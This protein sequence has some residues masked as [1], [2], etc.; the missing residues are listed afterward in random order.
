MGE[1]GDVLFIDI[2]PLS[3]GIETAGGIMTKLIE[4]IAYARSLIILEIVH[5]H[6]INQVY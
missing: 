6:V 3:L 1:A 2:I 5:M 4:S